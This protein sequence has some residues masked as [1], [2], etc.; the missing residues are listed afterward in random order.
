MANS[1]KIIIDIK[2]IDEILVGSLIPWLSYLIYRDLGARKAIAGL[3]FLTE[4][5]QKDDC[6]FINVD[7]S[8]ED[9]KQN[10]ISFSFSIDKIELLDF[11]SKMDFFVNDYCYGIVH[12]EEIQDESINSDITENIEKI[13]PEIMEQ[14][15]YQ[16][17]I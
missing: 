17:N 6:L 1:N 16:K 4:K 14:Q 12:S 8:L 5:N 9:M 7:E 10:V 11:S 2:C 3:N 13:K 15:K